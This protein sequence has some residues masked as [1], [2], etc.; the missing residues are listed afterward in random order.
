MTAFTSAHHLSLSWASSIQPTLPHPTSWRSILIL[1]SYLHLCF[2]SCLF[3]SGFP[4]KILYTPLLSPIRAKC[5][6]QL[7]L[8]D[9][10][11]YHPKSIGWGFPCV[12]WSVH[13][14]RALCCQDEYVL[15]NGISYLWV[16]C[17]GIPSYR[18]F[19]EDYCQFADIFGKRLLPSVT[20][21]LHGAYS[22]LR[23]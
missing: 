5:P 4:I 8:L 6:V 1:S 22:F 2:P 12:K 11:F 3:P 10:R 9:F 13:K 18:Q 14:F 20:Y 19:G 15:F 16:L 23:S 7:I 21:L 17:V